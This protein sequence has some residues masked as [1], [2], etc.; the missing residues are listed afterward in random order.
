[1]QQNKLLQVNNL[2]TCFYTSDGIVKAVDDVSWEVDEGEVIG[3]VGESGCGKSVSA[4]AIL[5]LVPEPPGKIVGGEILFK[6]QNLLMLSIKEMQKIRGNEISMIFQEPMTSLNPVFTI[7]DQIA[8]TIQL[9]QKVKKREALEKAIEMLNLVGMPSPDKRVNEY[10]HELSGGMK[11]RAMIAM[12]LSCNPQVLIADEPTTALDVTIQAQ[13]LDLMLKMK[14]EFRA[15]IVLITHDLGIIAETAQ[16]VVVMYAGKVM[17]Q[18]DVIEIFDNP[19]HPYTQGLLN[20]L[21]KLNSVHKQKLSTIPGIVPGLYDL[22]VGCK[23]SPR[24]N[25]VMDIC[26]QS[27]PD[28]IELSKR[29]ISRCWLHQK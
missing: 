14:Q 20:S 10:P 28:L 15:A 4:L 3:I 12:A 19:G 25:H 21:P 17:E 18:A 22:P 1:M 6:G 27:E 8:E 23:F 11:Q 24:C 7:G 29:H 16:K 9:H 26:P 13:I 5:R 2:K